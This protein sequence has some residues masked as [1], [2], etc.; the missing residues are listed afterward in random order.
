MPAKLNVGREPKCTLCV[1]TE[2]L[3]GQCKLLF[4][5]LKVSFT[6]DDDEIKPT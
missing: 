3:L 6:V 2:V 1:L 5:E 4:T